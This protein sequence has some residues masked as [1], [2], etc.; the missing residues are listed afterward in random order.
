MA[1]E[2]Y[3]YIVQCADGT[4]YTGWT[5]D[6]ERRLAM[7]NHGRGAAYTRMRRPVQLVYAERLPSRAEAMRRE[8]GLKRL[9]RADKALLIRRAQCSREPPQGDSP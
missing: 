1:E 4:Y 7:H 5:C 2:A 8:Q 3:A 6:V 9:S